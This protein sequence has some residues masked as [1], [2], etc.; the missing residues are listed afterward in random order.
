[1]RLL[2]GRRMLVG[3][4]PRS[5]GKI[6]PKTERRV[7][8]GALILHL[9]VLALFLVWTFVGSM[10]MTLPV[11]AVAI[12]TF[13]VIA[14]SSDTGG[15]LFLECEERNG[16]GTTTAGASPAAGAGGAGAGAGA[17]G[18]RFV[19]DAAD[20][21]LGEP[22]EAALGLAHVMG[23]NETEVRARMADG[24]GAV[25][26]EFEAAG[27]EADMRYLK[28]VRNLPISPEE[29]SSMTCS[30]LTANRCSN[31]RRCLPT[32]RSPD[33]SRWRTTMA[34]RTRVRRVSTKGM[35]S[36]FACTPHQVRPAMSHE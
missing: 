28:Q 12:T 24:V 21:V 25:I 5:Y 6:D 32:C 1:M 13:T 16:R 29:P 10:I 2:L 17:S 18:A 14:L 27:T 9:S 34:T 30:P 7:H 22:R 35:C 36:P 31:R 19:A 33:G 4:G 26:K 8:I 20:L 15:L 11:F 3:D 23:V